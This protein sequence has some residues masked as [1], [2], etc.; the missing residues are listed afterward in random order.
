MKSLLEH[1]THFSLMGHHGF[2]RA[3]SFPTSD[4]PVSQSPSFPGL[5]G[6]CGV[7]EPGSQ[8]SPLTLPRGFI[9]H[10]VHTFRTF[11]AA[12]RVRHLLP[13]PEQRPHGQLWREGAAAVSLSCAQ[14]K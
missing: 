13:W 9:S 14:Q 3:S 11:L 1:L 10:L 2:G 8:T 12:L 6:S 5:E 4:S 7:G